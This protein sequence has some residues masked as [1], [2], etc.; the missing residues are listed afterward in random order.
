MRRILPAFLLSAITAC[1][2]FG[3]AV[4]PLLCAAI[5]SITDPATGAEIA[6]VCPEIGAALLQAYAEEGNAGRRVRGRHAGPCEPMQLAMIESDAPPGA[7]LCTGPGRLGS[8]ADARRL[9]TRAKEIH[10]ERAR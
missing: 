8:E 5:V 3:R 4:V 9:W 10:A 1:A 6:K 2:F 7:Y